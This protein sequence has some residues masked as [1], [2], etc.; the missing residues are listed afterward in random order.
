MPVIIEIHLMAALAALVLGAAQFAAR[1]GTPRH[2]FVG[3]F[4]FAAMA[5]VCATSAGIYEI[6]DGKPSPIHLLTVIT[7]IFM[8]VAIVA[9]RKGN[10]RRHKRALTGCY[11]GLVIAG[12]FALM[13]GRFIA[14]L[15]GY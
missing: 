9:A 4:W 7:V 14:R 2:R 3:R 1:K 15:L 13:P 12:L 6:N 8:A 11:A 5:V 10:I